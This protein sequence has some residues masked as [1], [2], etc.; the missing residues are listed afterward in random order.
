MWG[1]FL[2][3]C[4]CPSLAGSGTLVCFSLHKTS[5]LGPA[6]LA[7]ACLLLRLRGTI[8]TSVAKLIGGEKGEQRLQKSG[9]KACPVGGQAHW[10]MPVWLGNAGDLKLFFSTCSCPPLSPE[11]FEQ[12]CGSKVLRVS[13]RGRR[14][15]KKKLY[16]STRAGRSFSG[17]YQILCA[18]CALCIGSSSSALRETECGLSRLVAQECPEPA[19]EDRQCTCTRSV[20]SCVWQETISD[21]LSRLRFQP[22]TTVG[23]NQAYLFRLR[24][25]NE[26]GFLSESGACAAFIRFW[27]V[28]AF[29]HLRWLRI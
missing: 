1:L 9:S 11:A 21:L 18:S 5:K 24:A 15:F 26:A 2:R 7:E 3:L 17:S 20:P 8:L 12:G 19:A 14:G 27:S 10:Q 6:D 4:A 25:A 23:G 29:P 22:T 16:R 13:E 28:R